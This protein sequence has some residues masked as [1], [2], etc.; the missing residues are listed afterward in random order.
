MD[1]GLAGKNVIVTGGSRGIGKQIALA[2]GREGANVAICARNEGPLRDTE[3]EIR[4]ENVCIYAAPCD[5]GDAVALDA[6]LDAARHELGGV[7]IF[8]HNPSGAGMT[9]D[10]AGWAASIN[11]DL[12]AAV[13]ATWK[14]L[15][16]M[17]ESGGGCF[18][19]IS[20]IAGLEGGL[21]TSLR[22]GKGGAHQLCKDSLGVTGTPA[23]P[24]QYNHARL[25]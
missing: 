5:I 4:R 10:P 8:V 15:P 13:R 9:D 2:F 17:I 21:E 16:W 20:S 1:L 12:M 25:R 14:V 23:S 11:V 19:F 3:A 7:D 18:L 24:R 6:F 22:C